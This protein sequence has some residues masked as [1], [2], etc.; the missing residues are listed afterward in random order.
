MDKQIKLPISFDSACFCKQIH[1]THK[2]KLSFN[3]V[4]VQLDRFSPCTV[5][6]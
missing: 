5:F 3:S 1:K 2:K 4:R 6:S